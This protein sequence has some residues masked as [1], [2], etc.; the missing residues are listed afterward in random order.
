[1]PAIKETG[2]Y[3]TGALKNYTYKLYS[4]YLIQLVRIGNKAFLIL[5]HTDVEDIG[6][7]EPHVVCMPIGAMNLYFC[8]KGPD[9]WVQRF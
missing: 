8:Q 1:M 3:T 5:S 6:R 4:I 2:P 7:L 9:S